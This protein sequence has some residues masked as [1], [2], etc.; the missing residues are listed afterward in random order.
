MQGLRKKETSTKFST[1]PATAGG[2]ASHNIS[3]Q[4][5][6]VKYYYDGSKNF[7]DSCS[8][9]I[10]KS[11]NFSRFLTKPYIIQTFVCQNPIAQ[12]LYLKN[13]CLSNEVY[14]NLMSPRHFSRM[15]NP[16]MARQED[17]G[18]ANAFTSFTV[19]IG[20]GRYFSPD[21]VVEMSNS[22]IED[23]AVAGY[24]KINHSSFYK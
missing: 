22:I 20:L 17:E 19:A 21:P 9:K 23:P 14:N 2:G 11:L 13:L 4:T 15:L 8:N 7:P 18:L 16:N 12:T 24:Q 1:H 3:Y 5:T 10:T 6:F